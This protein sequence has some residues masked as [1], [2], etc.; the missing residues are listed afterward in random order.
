M[1]FCG[2]STQTSAP[3][4]G[5]GL[6]VLNNDL[7]YNNGTIDM[8]ITSGGAPLPQPNGLTDA[9]DTNTLGT[10]KL[11]F[12]SA[13]NLYRFTRGDWGDAAS[14]ALAPINTKTIL[15]TD[16]GALVIDALTSATIGSV[17]TMTVKS[18][19]DVAVTSGTSMALLTDIGSPLNLTGGTHLSAGGILMAGGGCTLNLLRDITITASRAVDINA[20]AGGAVTIDASTSVDST[21][22]LINLNSTR[23]AITLTAV[24]LPIDIGEVVLDATGDIVFDP[25]DVIGPGNYCTTTPNTILITDNETDPGNLDTVD[26]GHRN[27]QNCISAR[28]TFDVVALTSVTPRANRWNVASAA[29]TVPGIPVAGQY[30][31]TLNEAIP[32]DASI[33]IMSNT[34]GGAPISAAAYIS[35]ALTNIDVVFTSDV[36]VFSLMVVGA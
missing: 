26:V 10:G 17:S 12:I 11:G 15:E 23:G 6:F 22:K 14:S 19:V 13:G 21:A 3:S 24:G 29:Y 16:S 33:M 30:S 25:G 31:V 5:H 27:R 35:G 2:F 20:G 32:S 28:A 34:P 18:D 1:K 7:Y 8:A 36:T 9:Y 4:F